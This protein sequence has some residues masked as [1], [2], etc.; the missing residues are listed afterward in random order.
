MK[1]RAALYAIDGG[2]A[3]GKETQTK[4][5]VEYFQSVGMKVI[6]VELP[7]KDKLTH[8]LIRWTLKNGLAASWPNSFQML[9]FLNKCLFQAFTLKKLLTT[10]D[11]VILDRWSASNWVYGTATNVNSMLLNAMKD[12][13][14]QPDLTVIIHGKAYRKIAED[15]YEADLELQNRVDAL[16]Q[17]LAVLDPKMVLVSTEGT[18]ENIHDCI[19]A[20]IREHEVS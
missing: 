15:V 10:Y 4:L 6:R 2:D 17:Y 19:V 18:K 8:K 16:Y 14:I 13:L 1:K 7:V 12:C 20:K 9:Q 3:R 11:V 5:L